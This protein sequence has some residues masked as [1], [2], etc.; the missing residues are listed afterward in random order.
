MGFACIHVCLAAD[1]N[2]DVG[3]FWSDDPEMGRPWAWC[4]S[5]ERRFVETD[6]DWKELT[7]IADFKLLCAGCWDD[8]KGIVGRGR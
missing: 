8:V 7:R 3:F 2:D 1:S 5:C 4:R 6:S